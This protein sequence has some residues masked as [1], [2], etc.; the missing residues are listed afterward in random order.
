[1]ASNLTANSERDQLLEALDNIQRRLEESPNGESICYV[2]LR[3]EVIAEA[4]LL[5]GNIPV[6]VCDLINHARQLLQKEANEPKMP[7]SSS[8][9]EAPI[10]SEEGRRGRPKL[11]ISYEQMLFFKGLLLCYV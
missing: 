9:Y 6:Q 5:N 1:M 7:E 10:G 4:A 11:F 2:A 8:G 3:L